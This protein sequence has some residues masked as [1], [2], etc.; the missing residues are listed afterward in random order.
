MTQKFSDLRDL[1]FMLHQRTVSGLLTLVTL[2]E[3]RSID[4][5]GKCFKMIFHR[6]KKVLSSTENDQ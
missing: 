4:G 2:G 6:E 5:W 3:V 1:I